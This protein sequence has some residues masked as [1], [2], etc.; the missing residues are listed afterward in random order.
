MKPKHF[1]LLVLSLLAALPA[2]PARAQGGDTLPVDPAVRVG[3]LANGLTYYVRENR[4]P[5]ERAELRLVVDAGSVLEDPDQRGLAHLVEHMAFNG[6]RSFPEHALTDYLESTGMRFG[7]D[8]NA[9]TGFDETVYTLTLPTDTPGVLE[10]GVRIL[11]EWAHDVTFDPEEVRRERGVVME[12]WRLGQGAAARLRDAHFPVLFRGSLYAERLPIGTRESLE[13]FT[14]DALVRFYREWYRPGL[15]AVVAV[16]DFDAAEVERLVRERFADLP[17]SPGGEPRPLHPVPGHEEA[18]FSVVADPEATRA[19]V[20][21]YHKLPRAPRGTVEAY[22][23]G[24]VESIYLGMLNDRLYERTQEPDAPYLSASASS[25]ALVR[26][27]DLHA[28]S[29]AVKDDGVERG[30]EA[31]LTEAERAAR[32][33]FTPSEM[34]REKERLLRLWEKVY[35]EREQVHSGQYAAE[36]VAHFLSGEGIPDVE[37]EF[38]LH[39]RFLPEVTLEEVN[40]VARER[41]REG[42]RVVLIGLPEKEGVR[43]PEESALAAVFDSVQ[44]G[45]VAAY[46]DRVSDAPLVSVPP[47]PGRIVAE[48]EIPELDVREWTLSNGAKVVVKAT[49]FKDDEFLFAAT[50]PGGLSLAPDSLY[51]P[52]MTATGVVHTAGV[53]DLDLVEL[54]KRLSGKLVGVGA[55]VGELREGFTGGGSPRDVE[56]LFQLVYLYFTAPRTDSSA[57]LA[58]QERA[59]A[60]LRNRGA[61]PEAAFGDTLRLALTQDHPR[62]R[63]IGSE[64]FDRMDLHRSLAFYRDR[65]ADAGDFTFYF[66]G[67]LDP[68]R[69]RPLVETWLGGLPSTGREESWRDV[70]VRYPQGVV[71]KT[72]RRGVE[73]KGRTQLVFTGPFGFTAENLAAVNA[74]AE[75]L[76]LRLRDV[77]REDLGGTYGAGVSASA[78]RDPVSTYSVGVGF[79][80]DPERLEELTG[81]VFAQIDSLKAHGPTAE[82]MRKVREAARREHQTSL[83]DNAFWLSQLLWY[84]KHGWDPRA[85]LAEEERAEALT[86]EAVRDAARRYLD[87]SRYVQVSLVPE[88][89]ET[90]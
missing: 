5:R 39:R 15:M 79:G 26:S 57:F 16:G 61:S 82:E 41:I 80:A 38:E 74:M 13:G 45:E 17:A 9:Y 32:H 19:T 85:I 69:L 4:E 63:P 88:T 47:T 50:S 64:T 58:Y 42:S 62:T 40:R 68:D 18:L 24:I 3:R 56:T 75:V 48:R 65:F 44:R 46:D 22:R 11:R 2:A 33:G 28:L 43:A 23:A 67:S 72:V 81:V 66:V 8:V 14:Y 86:A 84:G 1:P 78:S 60:S 20:A 59:Q 70:G 34:E 71:R 12:E 21:V 53:G 7:P 35:A 10:T 30:L 36:F 49:D 27:A 89:A 76:Q 52:A 31:L 29:A 83:R 55:G 25:G 77:L 73:P 51:V 90:K 6:T 87:T 37:T 54:G